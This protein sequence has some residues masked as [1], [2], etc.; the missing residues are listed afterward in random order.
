MKCHHWLG[1]RLLVSPTHLPG[2]D[3]L[4]GASPNGLLPSPSLSLPPF[5]EF[6]FL[7]CPPSLSHHRHHRMRPRFSDWVS[8]SGLRLRGGKSVGALVGSSLARQVRGGGSRRALSGS[9]GT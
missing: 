1:A 4:D 6:L 2:T 8:E 7:P 5:L 9:A 3:T